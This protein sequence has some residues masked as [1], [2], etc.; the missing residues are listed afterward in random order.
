[1]TIWGAVE[2]GNI[3]E[4]E[5]YLSENPDVNIKAVKGYA[6][7]VFAGYEAYQHKYTYQIRG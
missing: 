3:T 6:K 5:K 7:G 4:V 2:K 1:M